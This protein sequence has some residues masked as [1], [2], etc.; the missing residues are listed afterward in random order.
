MQ[1]DEDREIFSVTALIVNKCDKLVLAVS[2]KDDPNDFGLPGGKIEPGE[3]PQRAL[4]RELA[5]E[6]GLIAISMRP[7]YDRTDAPPGD[8]FCRCFLI[9]SYFGTIKTKE[10]G[11]VKWVTYDEL[12]KGTFGY[13]NTGL[14]EERKDLFW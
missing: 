6:T 14:L 11:V 4:R 5:E 3:L 1:V 8:K 12:T 13:Y 10:K 9:E 7:V 2:R